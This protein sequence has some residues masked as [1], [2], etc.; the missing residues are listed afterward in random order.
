MKVI[1][2]VIEVIICVVFIRI[3]RGKSR[4]VKNA[5]RDEGSEYRKNLMI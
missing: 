5:S 3:S 4:S 1:L 2:E